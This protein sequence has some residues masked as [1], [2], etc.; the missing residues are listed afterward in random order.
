MIQ[1]LM[2]GGH[3]LEDIW[4]YPVWQAKVFYEAR[5]REKAEELKF[6][7]QIIWGQK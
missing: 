4:H 7:A 5:L 2:S 3:K 1:V 6:M